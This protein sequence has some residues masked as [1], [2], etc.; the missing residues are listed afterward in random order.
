MKTIHLYLLAFLASI[1]A[2]FVVSSQS[3]Q[4]GDKS[5]FG[6][7]QQYNPLVVNI[8]TNLKELKKGT[9]AEPWQPAVFKV[10]MGDSVAL[11]LDVQIA[12]RGKMRRKTCD[13][14]P[15]K[16]RFYEQ[17][18]EN[19]SIADINEIKLVTSCY[20]LPKN[21]EWVQREYL[22][23]EL[24]NLITEQSF[25]VKSAAVRFEEPGKR[26][27]TMESFSFFIE[28]EEE[29]AARLGGRPMKPRVGSTRVLDSVSYDRMCVFEYMI[30]NTDWSV[31]ARHNI[32][33]IFLNSPKT[34]IAVPYDFD[35]S[36]AVGTDYAAPNGDYPIQTVQERYYLGLC[37]TEAHYQQIFDFYLSKEKALTDH[38]ERAAYLPENARKQM[39]R[40]FGQF[41]DALKDPSRSKREIIRNCNKGR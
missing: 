7:L 12:P 20:S 22:V 34:I 23:Y 16:I 8:E 11:Q 4:T 30:G 29:L 36:G 2:P 15:V 3:L 26:N 35:Y 33:L 31:R 14:P 1:T 6:V 21:E 40:Y 19:D 13:F 9:E 10:M 41:F 39:N 25:R 28:S 18:P 37:R 5:I 38:C 17:K 27:R 32:K 24:Y